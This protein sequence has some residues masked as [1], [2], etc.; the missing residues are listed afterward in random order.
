M[1]NMGNSRLTDAK[2]ERTVVKFPGLSLYQLSRRTHW[3]LG[4]ID[5]AVSRLVNAKRLFV[6][7]GEQNGR[8][9]S[10]IFP[11]EYRPTTKVSVPCHVLQA[12]NPTWKDLAHVYALDNNT[13]GISGK[14]L[15]YWAKEAKFTAKIPI[16]KTESHIEFV[17]PKDFVSFYQLETHFFTKAVSANNVLISVGA[18][19][20]E[21]RPYP[22]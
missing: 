14:P 1:R 16:K 15:P 5:G 21:K 8:R 10:Q 6:V 4:K 3:S 2:V 9:Q 22:S 17:I 19:I 7:M 13:I 20:Q 12:G 11:T 18:A